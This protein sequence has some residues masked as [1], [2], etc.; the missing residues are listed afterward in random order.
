[1]KPLKSLALILVVSVSTAAGIVIGDFWRPSGHKVSYA[2][3]ERNAVVVDAVFR[4]GITD[5][6]KLNRIVVQPIQKIIDDYT[7]KGFVVIDVT[8]DTSCEKTISTDQSQRCAYTLLGLPKPIVEITD[9]LRKA[10]EAAK[11]NEQAEVQK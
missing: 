9:E 2:L 5:D 7:H 10:V 1:M 4:D 6:K 11:K 8:A 3:M